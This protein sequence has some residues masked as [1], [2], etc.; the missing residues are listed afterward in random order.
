MTTQHFNKFKG[1]QV[2]TNNVENG[3]QVVPASNLIEFIMINEDNSENNG[4]IV[5]KFLAK[6]NVFEL[7]SGCPERYFGILVQI[8]DRRSGFRPAKLLIC[9]QHLL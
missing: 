5:D 9:L 7:P 6:K 2:Q 1:T 8:S 4:T 3:E